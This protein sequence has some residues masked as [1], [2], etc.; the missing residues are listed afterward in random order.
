MSAAWLR[1]ADACAEG[2]GDALQARPEA[3]VLSI[4]TAC[5][6]EVAT[7]LEQLEASDGPF[8]LGWRVGM[9]SSKFELRGQQCSLARA[10][11]RNLGATSCG[12]CTAEAK[13]TLSG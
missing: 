3:R 7:A 11:S 12:R 5:C 1:V 6:N 4:R 13:H 10:P 2:C 8:Y 9:D